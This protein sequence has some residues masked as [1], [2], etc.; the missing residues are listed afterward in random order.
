[1]GWSCRGR[2]REVSAHDP[3]QH[4]EDPKDLFISC[5]VCGPGTVSIALVESLLERQDLW[6]HLRPADQNLHVNKTPRKPAR[7]LKSEQPGRVSHNWDLTPG[8]ASAPPGRSGLKCSCP[9]LH[10]GRVV[11]P[12]LLLGFWSLC[13]DWGQVGV[14]PGPGEQ[15]LLLQQMDMQG[16]SRVTRGKRQEPQLRRGQEGHRGGAGGRR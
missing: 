4:T 6:S 3:S 12:A 10:W 2:G 9:G 14:S 11:G 16:V 1:M 7:A 13:G 8:L 5:K 15:E